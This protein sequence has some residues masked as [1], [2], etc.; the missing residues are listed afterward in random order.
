LFQ[1]QNLKKMKNLFL[2]FFSLLILQNAVAQISAKLMRYTDV[3]ETQITF[4]YG[5]DIWIAAKTGGTALQIT[6]SPG[7]ESWPKFSPD[8]KHI[9]YT[10]NYNGNSDVF[11]IPVTGGIPTRVTYNSFSDR[12]IDW[13]PNGKQLLFAANRENGM[14]RLNQF[15]L[16]EKEGGFPVK[17]NIPYGELASFS[18]NGDKLA[19]ITKITENYPFKRYRGGLTSDIIIY[20]FKTDKT[21]R[22]TTDEANDGKPAWAGDKVYFLSDRDEN[23]RLNI[24]E[25]NTKTKETKQITTYKDF[26]ISSLSAGPSELVYEMGGDLFLMNLNTQQTRK[27]GDKRY[28]RFIG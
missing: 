22:I 18:P 23:M 19:Y 17:L 25:Y 10:A 5:G 21:E 15:F 27:G 6:N 9:A 11:V 3:S 4:V 28:Q 16:V 13:H 26:D 14:G 2:L 7:E 12:L 1:I 24:W 8:G 20:D